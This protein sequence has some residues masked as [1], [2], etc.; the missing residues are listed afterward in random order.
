MPKCLRLST[1]VYTVIAVVMCLGVFV[2]LK[3]YVSTLG[4][5]EKY[6]GVSRSLCRRDDC[7]EF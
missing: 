5:H 2:G 7:G 1:C 6:E 3:T 4:I